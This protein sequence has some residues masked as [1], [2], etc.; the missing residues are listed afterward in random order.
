LNVL[1]VGVV[2]EVVKLEPDLEVP[3]FG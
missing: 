2:E 3:S 1:K